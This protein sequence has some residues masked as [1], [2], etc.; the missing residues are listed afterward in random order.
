MG[1]TGPG[2][3]LTWCRGAALAVGETVICWHP[4]YIRSLPKR[5]QKGEGRCSNKRERAVQQIENSPMTRQRHPDQH[6]A[7]A[8]AGPPRDLTNFSLH[9]ARRPGWFPRP[10]RDVSTGLCP[11]GALPYRRHPCPA[12]LP[13]RRRCP[14]HLPV[15]QRGRLALD[16]DRV[17]R[18]G[19]GRFGRVVRVQTG[20]R[21][22]CRVHQ[23]ELPDI[24]V[25]CCTTHTL[26]S[27]F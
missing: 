15:P 4:F 27:V 22:L 23:G 16:R 8:A 6:L 21:Q 2:R 17:H 19:H 1:E 3:C 9:H 12:S 11:A 18:S 5:L 24:A 13:Q 10:L 26:A 7:G 20:R 14:L 25:I